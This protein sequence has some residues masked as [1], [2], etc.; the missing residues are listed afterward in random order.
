MGEE[1][2]MW[3]GG[4][5]NVGGRRGEMCECVREVKKKGREG[6]MG[7][8]NRGEGKEKVR[9]KKEIAKIRPILK[10]MY[11]KIVCHV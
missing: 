11:T 5:K 2:K 8:K 7:E 6:N 1:G 10:A 4:G 9:I 3:G